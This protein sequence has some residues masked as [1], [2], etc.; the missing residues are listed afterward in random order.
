V[1]LLEEKRDKVYS[2]F[3]FRQTKLVCSFHQKSITSLESGS[4]VVGSFT[5]QRE[6]NV[7]SSWLMT[8]SVI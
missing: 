1:A 7:C 2:L 4:V 6:A 8:P 3:G 5:T